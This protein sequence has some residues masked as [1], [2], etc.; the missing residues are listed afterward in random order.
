[1]AFW[2]ILGIGL[3]VGL[4]MVVWGV[5]LL[6]PHWSAEQTQVQIGIALLTASVISVAIFVLQIVDEDRLGREEARRQEGIANQ[7]LRIQ[8]ALTSRPLTFMD[9]SGE[10]L[11]NVNLPRRDL[12]GAIFNFAELRDANLRG[13][14]LERASFVSA[15]LE[16]A[17]LI[18]AKL[19]LADLE[20]ANLEGALM[21]FATLTRAS[22]VDTELDRAE[23]YSADLRCARALGANFDGAATAG[24]KITGLE[25]DETTVFPDGKTRECSA[26][27]CVVRSTCQLEPPASP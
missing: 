10:N 9:L 20:D 19:D 8:L 4:S 5:R 24:W 12:S 13:A 18:R 16:G 23:L 22:L 21:T 1:V 2:L 25:Y 15:S 3:A 6:R 7:A 14:A 11:R 27:P 17:I 26:P